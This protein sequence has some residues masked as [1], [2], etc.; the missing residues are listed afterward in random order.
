MIEDFPKTFMFCNE[1]NLNEYFYKNI[2]NLISEVIEEDPDYLSRTDESEYLKYLINKYSIRVPHLKFEEM[3]L[4]QINRL[5]PGKWFPQQF[6][7]LDREKKYEKE[8]YKYSI[9]FEGDGELFKLRSEGISGG[10]DAS[11]YIE[12]QYLCFELINFDGN[13]QVIKDW[14][15]NK[16]GLI[17][18]KYLQLTQKTHE[19]SFTLEW[20]A[21][22]AITERKSKI[23]NISE[24]LG[25][26]LKKILNVPEVFSPNESK[27]QLVVIKPSL[28]EKTHSPEYVLSDEI[29][30]DILKKIHDIGKN[31]ERHPSTHLGKQ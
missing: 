11:T 30:F 14:A 22:N 19:F 6:V 15:N 31:F 4:W 28:N 20:Q 23:T 16:L 21:Q 1:G 18:Q 27:K 5:I 2:E 10:N 17:K 7:F 13:L 25:V 26:P 24:I 12:N 29:Y 9:P 3:T 8:V